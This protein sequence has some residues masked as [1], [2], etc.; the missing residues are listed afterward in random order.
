[1]IKSTENDVTLIIKDREKKNFFKKNSKYHSFL[2]EFFFFKWGKIIF[3]NS[4]I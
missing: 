3:L 4:I 2:F 1:M